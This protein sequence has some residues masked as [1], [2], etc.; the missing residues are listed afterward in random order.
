MDIY[1]QTETVRVLASLVAYRVV[2]QF[3]Y[4]VR[5]VKYVRTEQDEGQIYGERHDNVEGLLLRLMPET[6]RRRT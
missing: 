2:L 6:E 5:M 1:R 3:C 4:R